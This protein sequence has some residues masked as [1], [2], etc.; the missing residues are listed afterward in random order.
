MFLAAGVILLQLSA[1]VPGKAVRPV[2]ANLSPAVASAEISAV[3][4][5]PSRRRNIKLADFTFGDAPDTSVPAVKASELDLFSDPVMLPP[6]YIPHIKGK[7]HD[8]LR[9]EQSYP[10]R[11]WLA[12]MA[13]QHGA[14]AFDAYSTRYAVGH[15]ATEQ[16]PLLRP[17][18]HSPSIYAVSQLTPAALDLVGRRMQRSHNHFIRRLWWLPQTLSTATYIWAGTH[19]LQIA[20][21]R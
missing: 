8:V 12:L 18:A 2:Q 13:A 10:R 21:S 14:A 9:P 20:N 3:V 15:G 5:S 6:I 19:N 7:K 11:T 4:V 17:F 1:A 16:N